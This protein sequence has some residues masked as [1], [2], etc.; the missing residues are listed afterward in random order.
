MK[1]F[2][3]GIAGFIG[4]HLAD[5]LANQGHQVRGIDNLAGGDL[6]NV[7]PDILWRNGD[8]QTLSW[9]PS[10]DVVIHCAALAHEG[11]SLFSPKLITENVYG[12]SVAVFSAAIRS[13]VKRIV[14]L[15]SMARYGMGVPPF[16]EDDRCRP[17]DPYG[18][19][20]LAAEQTL[21]CLCEAHGVEYVIAVPHSIYGPRQKRDDPYR[22]VL[23][24][25]MNQIMN[26][27]A[28]II[29]GSGDQK[30]C[31]SYVDDV[32]PS[33]VKL[34]TE[35]GLSGEVI[36]IGPDE[37]VVTINEAC[38]MVSKAFAGTRFYPQIPM[39]YPGRPN[40]VGAA[41]CSSDKARRLLGYKTETSL[42]A[43]LSRVA[44]WMI[45]RGPLPFKYHLPLEIITERTPRTWLEQQI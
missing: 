1:I 19:A 4:S 44:D 16:K 20:K 21:R 30:R 12:A 36:N 31:F 32:I 5:A 3:T 15:S 38:R 34:A 39:Y 43:G 40:E 45:E 25:W 17:V 33:L 41:F 14:F 11:L 22:N 8:C 29:Y 6:E 13:G 18:I 7:S 23:A 37:G 26:H 24:I 10:T 28:P 35:P 42:Q 27:K 2:V 9:L